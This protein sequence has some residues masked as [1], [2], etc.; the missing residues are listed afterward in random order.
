[1]RRHARHPVRPA[2]TASLQVQPPQLYSR[3]IEFRD[4]KTMS[5][6]EVKPLRT[7]CPTVR[8]FGLL[9]AFAW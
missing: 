4:L 7:R 6:D 9:L 5:F 3:G 1:M 8:V 2:T